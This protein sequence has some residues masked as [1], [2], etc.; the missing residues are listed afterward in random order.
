MKKKMPVMIGV[1]SVVNIVVGAILTLSSFGVTSGFGVALLL[2]SGLFSVVVGIGL[3]RLK[4]W[5]RKAAIAGYILNGIVGLAEGN[6]IALIVASLILTYLLSKNVK[7]AFSTNLEQQTT[8]EKQ[9]NANVI[10][11]AP[12]TNQNAV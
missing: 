10:V 8:T 7:R 6:I 9:K 3:F 12:I 11:E 2:G 5:A 1:I 4:S